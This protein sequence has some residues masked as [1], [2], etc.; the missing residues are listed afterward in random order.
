MA[1][2]RTIHQLHDLRG[3]TALVTGGSRGLGLQIA[4]ALGEAG[5]RLLI[6]C[7]RQPSWTPQ[8]PS[9]ARPAT[10]W[11]PLPPMAATTRR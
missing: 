4:H 2:A 7:A 1:P 8:P 5:A 6:S 3:R 9:C 11:T 10:R